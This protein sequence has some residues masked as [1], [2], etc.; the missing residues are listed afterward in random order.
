MR[1]PLLI[2]PGLG[3]SGPAHWQSLWQLAQPE[4]RRVPQRNWEAPRCSDW[5]AALEQEVATCATPPVLVAH[6]LGCLLVAHW[7]AVTR[8]RAHAAL[9]VAP[10]DP[11][12]RQ[13][14]PQA[15]SFAPL[16]GAALPFPSVVVASADD[17]YASLASAQRR[18]ERWGSRF[19]DIGACG[20]INAASGLGD[21][22]QGRALLVELMQ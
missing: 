4:Y 15:S 10:P 5:I 14:P 9:L 20:H 12:G 17:P 21:W 2:L 8:H 11:E 19:I 16:P 1:R 3:D 18:A 6:S 7:A 13:F 22:P